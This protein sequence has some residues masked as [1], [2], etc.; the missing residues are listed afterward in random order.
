MSSESQDVWHLL[1]V[2]VKDEQTVRHSNCQVNGTDWVFISNLARP[3]YAWVSYQRLSPRTLDEL[4]TA[5]NWKD[6]YSRAVGM[7]KNIDVFE[8]KLMEFTHQVLSVDKTGVSET[9]CDGILGAFSVLMQAED[10]GAIYVKETLRAYCYNNRLASVMEWSDKTMQ[11]PDELI[12][13]GEEADSL[14]LIAGPD[15]VALHRRSAQAAN[16]LAEPD[17]KLALV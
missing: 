17:A 16:I 4:L 9:T 12:V 6:A 1:D 14:L 8:Q 11:K 2:C 5:N 3:L 13:V 7:H 10:D 15:T